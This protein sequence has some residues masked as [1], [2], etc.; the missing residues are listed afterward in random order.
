MAT[1]HPVPPLPPRSDGAH[2]NGAPVDP[3]RRRIHAYDFRHPTHFSKEALRTLH[4][5]HEQFARSLASSLTSLLRLSVR[6]QLE[7]VDQGSFDTYVDQLPP[8]PV[9]Y[10]LRLNPS[11]GACLF[12]LSMAPTQV[13]LDRLCGG[14]GGLVTRDPHLTE[15]ERALLQ[16]LGRHIVRAVSNAWSTVQPVSPTV[17]D[18]L[19]SARAARS[20]APSEVAAMA[21]FVLAVGEVVGRMTMCLPA[22]AI[23]PMMESL[24]ARTRSFDQPRDEE[25]PDALSLRQQLLD[26]PV[27]AVVELGRVQLPTA[28]VVGLQ[29]GHVIRLETPSEGELLLTI[30]G[31]PLYLCRP[32]LSS[33]RVGVLVSRRVQ[34][35]D[36]VE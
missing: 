31:Q 20:L 7:D 10:V 11:A 19:L 29:I 13:I 14:S 22:Q 15:I 30:E 18:I 1:T 23:E 28:E 4:A 35:S 24:V 5:I 27:S 16:P 9:L 6:I 33:G 8:L 34:P 2:S 26:V 3:G 21:T 17:D 32:G 36:I 12:E 25:S